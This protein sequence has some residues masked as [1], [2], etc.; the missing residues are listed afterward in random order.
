MIRDDPPDRLLENPPP[1]SSAFRSG[2]TSVRPGL[3]IPPA[4][5]GCGSHGHRH[6]FQSRVPLGNRIH[7]LSII[8]DV[9]G[10]VPPYRTRWYQIYTGVQNV[11]LPRRKVKEPFSTGG[12]G[13]SS[14][15]LNF[16]PFNSVGLL[17]LLELCRLFFPFSYTPQSQGFL[18]L[19]Y[20]CF[21]S[22]Q[23]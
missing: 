6:V 22:L 21:F 9:M 12:C 7:Q 1:S 8:S 23:H 19:N 16:A 3:I 20:G 10:L 18:L 17:V 5:I 11:A 4:L 2:S 13:R 14:F 15:P